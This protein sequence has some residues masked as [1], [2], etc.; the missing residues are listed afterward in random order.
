MIKYDFINH[1]G[2]LIKSDKPFL[3]IENRAFRY[4]D[5]LFETMRL[6]Q[7]EVLFLEEHL[8]RLKAGMKYLKMDIS[9]AFSPLNFRNLLRELS[10]KNTMFNA[11]IR[12]QVYRNDGGLYTPAT[13]ETS[14]VIQM[15]SVQDTH[16]F[17]NKEGLNI[18]LYE[19]VAKPVS[20]L[21]NLKTANS[22]YSV[23]AGIYKKEN[24]L[25]DCL[26]LNSEG[27]IAEAVSSNVFIVRRNIFYTPSLQSGCVSGIM[28]EQLIKILRKNKKRIYETALHPDDL[29]SANEV[30]LT[31]V[32]SGIRWVERYK[33]KKYSNTMAQWLL[34]KL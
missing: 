29:L 9:A 13:N 11:R 6:I 19:E 25:D 2:T 26:L 23:L 34:K 3:S 5:A 20:K 14:F 32:V 12:L 33:E 22:M 17:L 4:G 31:N 10:E 21:S 16:Y 18:A 30:F 1:N 15:E 7:G 8:K 24:N 27:N 28:R